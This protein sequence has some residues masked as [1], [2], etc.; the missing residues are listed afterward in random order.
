M[1]SEFRSESPKVER[2]PDMAGVMA[3]LGLDHE[4]RI[5]TNIYKVLLSLLGKPGAY[6]RSFSQ[7]RDPAH[8]VL[9]IL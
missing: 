4:S 2:L 6:P 5:Y 8:P 9:G 3:G 1:I 7:P